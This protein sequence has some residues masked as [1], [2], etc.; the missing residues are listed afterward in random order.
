MKANGTPV[1]ALVNGRYRTTDPAH[2]WTGAMAG[3]GYKD[4]GL[5]M[6]DLIYL[7]APPPRS[8]SFRITRGREALKGL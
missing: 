2:M 3:E 6:Y 7:F 8:L 1:G 4:F 5:Q